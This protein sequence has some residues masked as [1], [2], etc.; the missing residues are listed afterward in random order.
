MRAIISS[1]FVVALITAGCSS[2]SDDQAPTTGDDANVKEGKKVAFDPQI[3]KSPSGNFAGSNSPECSYYCETCLGINKPTSATL[4]KDFDSLAGLIWNAGTGL[5]WVV[6]YYKQLLDVIAKFDLPLD[7]PAIPEGTGALQANLKT[8]GCV[9]MSA[10]ALVKVVHY[11]TTA[12][13]PQAAYERNG[14]KALC[15]LIYAINACSTQFPVLPII[16]APV[17]AASLAC[18]GATLAADFI[19]CKATKEAC[20]SNVE[21]AKPIIEG[22]L[23]CCH[24]KSGNWSLAKEHPC[25]N[26]GGQFRAGTCGNGAP[27]SADQCSY[28][29]DRLNAGGLPIVQQH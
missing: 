7:I 22:N 21:A 28:L 13:S 26:A 27:F 10:D 9:A 17:K 3:C 12:A 25:L 19:V 18:T 23:C 14:G 16:A 2:A 1:V 4:R 20:I 29:N 6:K 24:E 5:D 15:G 8:A 11:F